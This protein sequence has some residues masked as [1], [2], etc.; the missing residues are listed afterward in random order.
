MNEELAEEA[1]HD[2]IMLDN[3]YEAAWAL[4]CCVSMA[5]FEE[6]NV[7]KEDAEHQFS[8]GWISAEDKDKLMKEIETIYQA[9][10]LGQMVGTNALYAGL[11]KSLADDS[12]EVSVLICAALKNTAKWEELTG[13]GAPLAEALMNS[14]KRVRY[15]AAMTVAALRRS[16]R[17]RTGS[18]GHEP[19][20]AAAEQA[21]RVVL[22]IESDDKYPAPDGGGLPVD[23]LLRDRGPGCQARD[24]EARSS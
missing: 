4:L 21:V 17:S 8:Q 3:G 9:E 23:R 15:A 19:C 16:R 18:G 13:V 2:A 20:D 11:A 22:I 6:A 10:F 12:A 24:H 1:C 7:A 14:D 5:Q